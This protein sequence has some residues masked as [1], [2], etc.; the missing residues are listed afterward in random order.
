MANLHFVSGEFGTHFIDRETTLME[1]MKRIMEQET[2]L[3]EK[4]TEIFD[5]SKRIAAIAAVTAITH[6]GLP[7]ASTEEE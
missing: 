3:E 7:E 1:D 4:L 6:A 2:P 5:D